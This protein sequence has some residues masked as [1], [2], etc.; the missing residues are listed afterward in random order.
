[1]AKPIVGAVAI[2]T[3]PVLPERG[4]DRVFRTE[5]KMSYRGYAYLTLSSSVRLYVSVGA[6]NYI[7]GAVLRLVNCRHH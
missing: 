4:K 7:E 6:W 1:M 3:S 2:L 5:G